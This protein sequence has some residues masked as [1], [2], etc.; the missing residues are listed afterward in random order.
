MIPDLLTWVTTVCGALKE[1][2]SLNLARF[3]VNKSVNK[4]LDC[5][6]L[7]R[8]TFRKVRTQPSRGF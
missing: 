2:L 6:P 8:V 3:E 4:S 1:R 5:S 7:T